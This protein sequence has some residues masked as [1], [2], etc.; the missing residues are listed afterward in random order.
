MI[1]KNKTWEL[2]DRP[3]DKPVIGV[4]WVYKTKLNFDGT[5][6]K[7]KARLVAKGYSKKPR[8]DFNETFAPVARRVCGSPP[9]FIIKNKEDKVYRLKKALYGLKQAPRAWYEEINSFFTKADYIIYTRSS[10]ALMMEFKT[11]MMRQYEMTDLGLLHHF[12]GLGDCK[13]VATP[14]TMNEKLSKEDGSEQADEEAE[15]VSAAEATAQAIWL[16]FVLSY[17]GEEQVGVTTILCDN[18]SAIAITK[19]LMHHHKTRHIN[20]RFHFIRDALQNGEID[21][22]YCKTE[23]Q[24]ADIFTKALVRDRFEYLRRKLGNAS[25]DSD[26]SLNSNIILLQ[27]GAFGKLRWD[28]AIFCL[29]EHLDGSKGV[30][31]GIKISNW[32][33][34][35]ICN[36][37]SPQWDLQKLNNL[38][39]PMDVADIARIPL[40]IQELCLFCGDTTEGALHVLVLCPF[41]VATWD[42]S[43]LT[44]HAHQHPASCHLKLNFDRAFDPTLGR[45][46]VRVVAR[47]GDGG[48]ALALS[49]G[50]ASP[51]F[52]GDSAVVVATV[53]RA[54]HDYSNIGTI[55][56]EVK[57][58]HKQ[59][60]GSVFQFTHREANGVVHRLARFGLL[61]VD[62]FT[63]FEVPPDLIQ[64]ALFCDVLGRGQA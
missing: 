33:S 43:M 41:A 32:V 39:L 53:K 44:R 6:Q 28:Q 18:T 25:Y 4:K 1:E 26:H 17:F 52:E 27:Y 31:D 35:L 24:I 30:G 9:S 16:R 12:L 63:W 54:G 60:P 3:T 2:V 29:E 45:G 11:E 10:K 15:Y 7:N 42:I 21:L 13:A 48:L 37:G 40:N 56:K 5:V 58:L 14:L 49:L 34:E 61:T 19:N 20:R 22:L 59:F 38:I 8:I 36:E 51:I 64:D 55:V 23:E 47:D 46:A 50:I 62:N 57:D